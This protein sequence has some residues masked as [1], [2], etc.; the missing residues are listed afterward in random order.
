MTQVLTAL[1]FEHKKGDIQKVLCGTVSLVDLL[2]VLDMNHRNKIKEVN[3]VDVSALY[4][5][6]KS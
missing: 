3:L 6:I 5:F 1:S 4:A 2:I